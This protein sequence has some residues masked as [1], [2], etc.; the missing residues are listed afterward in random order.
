[1]MNC[2]LDEE[3]Y[4]KV[5]GFV[6]DELK[7]ARESYLVYEL[8]CKINSKD[9]DDSKPSFSGEKTEGWIKTADILRQNGIDDNTIQ[10]KIIY[11]EDIVKAT[12]FIKS[13]GLFGNVYKSSVESFKD[14]YQREVPAVEVVAPNPEERHE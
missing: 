1:M 14:N 11:E 2:F 7:I 6:A 12:D 10:E 8:L 9:D 13:A 4:D 5:Q 3:T